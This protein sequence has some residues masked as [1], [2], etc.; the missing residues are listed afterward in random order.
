[1]AGAA[2]HLTPVT[3]ELGGKSPVIVADDAKRQGR[4]PPHRVREDAEL[5]PD[6]R[7]AG[8]RTGRPEGARQL[9]RRAQ[10]RHLGSSRPRPTLPIINTRQAGRI[11]GLVEQ[12][13]RQ[14]RPRR[15]GRR[16][17]QAR[18]THRH[19][20][21][22]RRLGG[23]ARRDLRPGAAAGHD[24]FDGRRDRARPAGAEAAR[25]LP[26]QREPGQ[27]EAR[28]GRDQQRRHG[29][30]PAHV[31]PAR[32]RAAVRRRRQQRHRGLPR[33]V[34]LTKRSATASR[35]C[36]SPPG[37]TRR[38]PTRRSRRSSR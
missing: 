13:R 17:R 16:R 7:G 35:C 8:L 1:M 2:K 4:G 28:G 26:V 18:R 31:P 32:Q 36:A 6:L 34:G 27:R 23:D 9:R 22:R 30:Q 5:R 33:Q 19:R 38:S 24:R 12:R 37:P 21:P 14:D 29:G 15:Q 25:G 11:A 10:Q 20:R 3:L